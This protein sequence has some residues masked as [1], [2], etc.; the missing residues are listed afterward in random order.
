MADV[1]VSYKRDD[2]DRIAPIIE[3]LEAANLSVWWDRNTAPGAS[4]KLTLAKELEKSV[5]VVV[6]WSSASVSAGKY[7]SNWVSAEVALAKER[8]KVLLPVL[9]DSGHVAR[10]ERELQYAD[11]TDWPSKTADKQLSILID[12]IKNISE[13]RAHDERELSNLVARNLMSDEAWLIAADKV[14]R[15]LEMDAECTIG[16]VESLLDSSWSMD[17]FDDDLEHQVIEMIDFLGGFVETHRRLE[18]FLAQCEFARLAL[19]PPRS[20]EDSGF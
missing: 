11:L 18:T 19:R 7:V 15:A 1:F 20:D 2:R 10:D 13:R 12:T 3:K 4:W 16:P 5:C 9:L 8:K 17:F 14:R 6:V